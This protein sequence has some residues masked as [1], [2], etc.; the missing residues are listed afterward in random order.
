MIE[1]AGDTCFVDISGAMDA[2]ISA[3]AEHKSQFDITEVEE[4]V[5]MWAAEA[6]KKYG[7][8]FA[9]SYRKITLEQPPAEQAM[10]AIAEGL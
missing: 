8:A 6:G 3:L 10:E 4:F 2:K 9:E 5:R 7:V 1:A